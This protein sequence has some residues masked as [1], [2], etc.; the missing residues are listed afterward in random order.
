MDEVPGISV[1]ICAY[2]EDRW[3]E[4]VAA[5]A[6]VTEQ[7]PPAREMILVIDHNPELLA[8]ASEELAG[9]V[10]VPNVQT[11]GLA[12]ARNSGALASSGEVVAFLDDDA[13]ARPGWIGEM[14]RGYVDPRVLGVGG[15]IDPLWP[16]TRPPWFP[17]EF[18]WV[19]GCTYRGM[20]L[21]AAP[22]RNLIGANMSVRREV[23]DAVNGFRRELGRLEETEFCIRTSV[24]FPERHWLFW[25]HARVGHRVSGERATWRYFRRRCSAEGFAK[26]TMVQLTTTRSGLASE[27]LYVL[28]ALPAGVLQGIGDALRGDPWGAVRAGA[29]V[30]GLLF[31]ATGYARGRIKVLRAGSDSP[32]LPRRGNAP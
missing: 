26:A 9:A 3:T 22:V 15:A 18:H 1:V 31:T 19:V 5:V 11:S 8:R 10:V 20:P 6:S 4:I 30:A 28:R 12:G 21:E 32:S 7:I 13:E 23:F 17:E 27:R 24:M 2:T 14:Q 16:G 29:I 25:P